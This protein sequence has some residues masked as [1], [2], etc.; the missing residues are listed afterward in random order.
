MFFLAEAL[1]ILKGGSVGLKGCATSSQL[2][3]PFKYLADVVNFL[4][5]VPLP[6]NPADVRLAGQLITT[7]IWIAIMLVQALMSGALS[8]SAVWYMWVSAPPGCPTW[9]WRGWQAL[10][11][12]ALLF[13]CALAIWLP[14]D[15]E[16][17]L[18]EFASI[19]RVKFGSIPPV[20]AATVAVL[21]MWTLEMRCRETTAAG[22]S[23]DLAVFTWQKQGIRK[24]LS[25]ASGILV[26]GVISIYVRRSLV[27]EFPPN[28]FA[29]PQI[30]LEA[31]AYTVMIG[32][33]YIPA[34]LAVNQAANKIRDSLLPAPQAW[35]STS[36]LDHQ[37]TSDGL[38]E[39]LQI[40]LNDWKSLGPG[41]AILAPTL[42]SLVAGLAGKVL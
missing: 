8:Y 23:R 2:W 10:A 26:F 18:G 41:F 11:F 27:L 4:H 1:F 7:R 15:P 42:L 28:F 24:A 39:M 17:R 37:K 5:C 40:R 16:W 19:I 20:F 9:R 34:H 38:D 25:T 13:G 22:G 6:D 31:F 14:S 21:A 12:R 29:K 33:A 32:L 30:V 36:V 3:Q 35:Q